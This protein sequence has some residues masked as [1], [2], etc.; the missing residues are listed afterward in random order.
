MVEDIIGELMGRGDTPAIIAKLPADNAVLKDKVE[1]AQA[2]VMERQEARNAEMEA[3]QTREENQ[4]PDERGKLR[5]EVVTRSGETNDT[6]LATTQRLLNGRLEKATRGAELTPAQVEY[7]AKTRRDFYDTLARQTNWVARTATWVLADQT[8]PTD[9]LVII[10]AAKWARGEKPE[11]A[12]DELIGSYTALVAENGKITAINLPDGLYDVAT[13][14]KMTDEPKQGKPQSTGASVLKSAELREKGRA[15][16][17]LRGPGSEEGVRMQ[18]WAAE[19]R[20]FDPEQETAGLNISEDLWHSPA[21]V[22]ARG[23]MRAVED[24]MGAMGLDLDRMVVMAGNSEFRNLKAA[25][26][27]R[28]LSGESRKNVE[29]GVLPIHK[30]GGRIFLKRDDGIL[31]YTDDAF[32]WGEADGDVVLPESVPTMRAQR[33]QMFGVTIGDVA[34]KGELK[35]VAHGDAEFLSGAGIAIMRE[36]EF[37]RAVDLAPALKRAWGKATEM[38]TDNIDDLK[39]EILAAYPSATNKMRTKHQVFHN[40]A[41]AIDACQ[42]SG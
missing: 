22:E 21:S 28:A 27:L 5:A 3:Q 15:H 10:Q 18:V 16:Y 9:D 41:A 26:Y 11:N 36:G 23:V 14:K 24:E 19:N 42:R 35:W 2:A 29:A 17:G 7:I 1:R 25:I 12:V 32:G 38:A 6:G 31:E 34:E 8:L 20:V 13:W 30:E 4:N 39:R 33:V 40:E 37:F